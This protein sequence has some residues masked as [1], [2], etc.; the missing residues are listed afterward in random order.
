YYVTL[1]LANQYL[2]L[3][4]NSIGQNAWTLI[5]YVQY[6]LFLCLGHAIAAEL[7]LLLLTLV[8]FRFLSPDWLIAKRRYMIVLAFVLGAFLTP[9]DVLTQLLLALPLI[10]LY[11]VAIWYAKW[12]QHLFLF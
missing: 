9:P 5:H 6:V 8:H 12:R 11:E 10:A 3:F 1:P 7:G 4:N 2:F